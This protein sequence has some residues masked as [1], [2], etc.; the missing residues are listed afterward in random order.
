MRQNLGK[1]R[2]RLTLRS[3]MSVRHRVSDAVNEFN[4]KLAP[5]SLELCTCLRK[6][7]LFATAVTSKLLECCWKCQP[8]WWRQKILRIPCDLL[9]IARGLLPEF[10]YQ[11]VLLCKVQDVTWR[12]RVSIW[13][14]RDH[15]KLKLKNPVKSCEIPKEETDMQL[16]VKCDQFVCF[17]KAWELQPCRLMFVQCVEVV[18]CCK[19]DW[20]GKV[21][22][23]L[24]SLLDR[25]LYY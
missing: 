12:C 5:S 13:S 15:L 7:Y 2:A 11:P 23:L 21:W 10:R 22:A 16:V 8:C 6:C 20:H 1:S 19:L 9:A 25:V 4:L 24:T 18:K 3:Q 17:S 14:R